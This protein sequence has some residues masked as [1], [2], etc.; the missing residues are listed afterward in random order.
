MILVHVL[1]GY[2]RSCKF[3]LGSIHPMTRQSCTICMMNI[4]GFMFFIY[5]F[6]KW[7]KPRLNTSC[8]VFVLSPKVQ[9]WLHQLCW[10]C[11]ERRGEERDGTTVL[12]WR[13][14]KSSLIYVICS[15]NPRNHLRLCL[16]LPLPAV[17]SS[18]SQRSD[19]C[20]LQSPGVV[21]S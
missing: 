14:D 18:M 8:S 20:E 4:L 9:Q 11:S 21:V 16:P 7:I 2:W 1:T 3:R 15:C 10:H 19:C 12:G 5:L 13:L 6:R 17:V